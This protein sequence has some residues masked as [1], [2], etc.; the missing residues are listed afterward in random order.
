MRRSLKLVVQLEGEEKYYLPTDQDIGARTKLRKLSKV[1]IRIT[2]IVLLMIKKVAYRRS[3]ILSVHP[4][5]SLSPNS[6][7]ISKLAIDTYS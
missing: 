1:E 4:L 6:I 2:Y 7:Y 3:F 5:V